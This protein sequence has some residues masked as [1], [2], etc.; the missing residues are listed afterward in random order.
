M[1]APIL[2][3]VCLGLQTNQGESRQ[4]RQ[5][6]SISP[7]MVRHKEATKS[8]L[9][10]PPWSF[11][12]AETI[13]SK[14][15]YKLFVPQN[16]WTLLHF[17]WLSLAVVCMESGNPNWQLDAPEFALP[18]LGHLGHG[19]ANIDTSWSAK[20]MR[21]MGLLLLLALVPAALGWVNDEAGKSRSG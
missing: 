4:A 13:M 12:R 14:D 21:A 3:E 1:A 17:H 16:A 15:Q 19:F 11:V 8:T 20:T 18:K 6:E 7:D 9:H 10:P 5:A 2:H